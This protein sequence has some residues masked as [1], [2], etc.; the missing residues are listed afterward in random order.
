MMVSHLPTSTRSAHLF[1]VA[2]L[3]VKAVAQ[4]EKKAEVAQRRQVFTG[5]FAAAAMTIVSK[6]AQADERSA[7]LIAKLCASNPTCESPMHIHCCSR[8]DAIHNALLV[9]H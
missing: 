8:Q 4:Q 7:A 1:L 3:Q 9:K 6:P 5:L 2:L